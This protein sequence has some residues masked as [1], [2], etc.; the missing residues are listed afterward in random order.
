MGAAPDQGVMAKRDYFLGTRVSAGEYHAILRVAN[1]HRM[2]MSQLIRAV[3]GRWFRNSQPTGQML[4]N[5]D[6]S[7]CASHTDER[8]KDG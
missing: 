3:L 8:S 5:L 7:Q 1:A 6:R 4:T 2:T